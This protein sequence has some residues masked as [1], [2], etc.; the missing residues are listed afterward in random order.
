MLQLMAQIK[1]QSLSLFESRFRNSRLFIG[2]S[3]KKFS[4]KR[5]L[6][7][8]EENIILIKK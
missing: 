7:Y 8:I 6:V 4:E 3:Q 5:K 2:F 1:D